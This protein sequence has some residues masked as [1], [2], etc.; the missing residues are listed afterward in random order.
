MNEEEFLKIQ[1]C[2][3]FEEFMTFCKIKQNNKK[4]NTEITQ[5]NTQ[6]NTQNN[7]QDNTQ[8]N[9]QDNTQNNTQDNTQN[10]KRFVPYLIKNH[11]IIKNTFTDE[12]LLTWAFEEN[13]AEGN[14]NYFDCKECLNKGYIS[15]I[16]YEKRIVI[17][18][19]CQCIKIRKARE[20]QLKF[21]EIYPI[22]KNYSFDNFLTLY[23]YQKEIKL[24]S[25]NFLNNYKNHWF[26]IGGQYGSGKSHICMAIA[27]ELIKKFK[28]NENFT[29]FKYL[30]DLREIKTFTNDLRQIEILNKY[31]YATVLYI[32]DFLKVD[33]TIADL[34][35]IYEILNYRYSKKLITLFSSEKLFSELIDL[36]EAIHSRIFELAED[37][38][39][40]ISRDKNRNFR[41]MKNLIT[42][43]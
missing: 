2:K 42:Q 16:D 10:K 43:I 5:D 4:D 37:F 32:D 14:L 15:F 34:K 29:L 25:M 33:L 39:L 24:K 31:K 6:D 11:K 38:I 13:K 12:E 35:I 27:N 36:D 18:K 28:S 7:T 1:N 22:L 30:E 17:R 40:D 19:E 23:N 3:N 8:N 9:T 41:Y 21:F 26:F 20:N